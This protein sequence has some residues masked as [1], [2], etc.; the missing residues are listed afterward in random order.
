MSERYRTVLAIGVVALSTGVFGATLV[1]ATL[2]A[3]E[4]EIAPPAAEQ[5]A[6]SSSVIVAA[7][8][9]PSRLLIPKLGVDAHVQYVGIAYSGNVMVPN[10]FTDVAWYKYGPVPGMAGSALID[11]HVD[12]GLNLPGVF[13]NLNN[14]A[15][16]DDVY[17]ETVSGEKLHFV[18]NEVESYPYQAVPTS[19]IFN[20]S[21]GAAHLNLITCDGGWVEGQRTYDHRF[22]VYTT[23]VS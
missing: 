9:Y 18:V 4:S 19:Q 2:F 11:G 5:P 10:N 1:H 7:G 6:A 15:P 12:N 13:K 20:S 21:D 16:G 3:P 22:V 23:L 17:V 14:I 8:N